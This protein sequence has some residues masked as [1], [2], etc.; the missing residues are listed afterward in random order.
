MSLPTAVN[1]QELDRLEA[2]LDDPALDEAMRLDEIQA[3]LCASM[4]GPQPATADECLTAIFGESADSSALQEAGALVAKIA[5]HLNAQLSGE[6]PFAL[7][8]YPS[9]EGDEAP[10][11]YGPWCMAYL[12]GVDEAIEDWFDNLD[13]E[14]SNFLDERLYPLIVLTGEA[15]AAAKEHGEKWPEGEELDELMKDCEEEVPGAVEDIHRFWMAKRGAPTQRREK[16]KVGRNDPCPCGSG[17]KY[18][19]CCGA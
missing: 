19:Q 9:A 13:E 7:W 11:D 18:K 1:E 5:Q 12:H 10:M 8:L 17:K 15:E 3:Y 6:E 4:S 16:P 14:E 2:L